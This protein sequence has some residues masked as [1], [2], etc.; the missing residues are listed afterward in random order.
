MSCLKIIKKREEVLLVDGTR[1][2]IID[3]IETID[4]EIYWYHKDKELTEDEIKN[5]EFSYNM[6]KR[7]VKE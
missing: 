6:T 7:D 5:L 4:N 1:L 3:R 2:F